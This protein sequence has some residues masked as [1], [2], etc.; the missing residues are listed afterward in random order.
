MLLFLL[1]KTYLLLTLNEYHFDYACLVCSSEQ[2]L[3]TLSV[4]RCLLV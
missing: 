4:I 3:E 2:K 1:I